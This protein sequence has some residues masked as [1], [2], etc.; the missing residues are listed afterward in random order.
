IPV[1]PGTDQITDTDTQEDKQTLDHTEE[2]DH[3]TRNETDRRAGHFPTMPYDLLDEVRQQ[4]VHPPSHR[5][6][7]TRGLGSL[8]A[9][10]LISMPTLPTS[11]P[12][13]SRT[14]AWTRR[15]TSVEIRGTETSGKTIK[16]RRTATPSGLCTT[17]TSTSLMPR[18]SLAERRTKV[19]IARREMR[20]W[21][22][23]VSWRMPSS[24][25]R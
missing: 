25:S 19:S 6:H 20:T 8:A 21:P 4:L 15:L 10:F 9:M 24:S 7:S 17:F 1:N 23:S 12:I 11:T 18:T 16:A 13:V 3:Q 5:P 14:W 22:S 2:H